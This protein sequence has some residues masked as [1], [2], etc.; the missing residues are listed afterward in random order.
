VLA[1]P[2][3]GWWLAQSSLPKSDGVA[4]VPILLK[5]AS[6][7]TDGRGVPNITATSEADLFRAQGYWT[8][9]ARLFQMDIYRRMARGE[10]SAIYGNQCLATDKLMRQIGLARLASEEF[11]VLSPEAKNSLKDYAAGVNE[12][13]REGEDHKSPEFLMLGYYP[14]T[15]T[16]ED[17]LAVLKYIQYLSEESWT[18]DDLKQRVLE[19]TGPVV[20]SQLFEHGFPQDPDKTPPA[21]P[22][23]K[24]PPDGV[25]YGKEL[26]NPA[27]IAACPDM[28]RLR[29]A[30]PSSLPESVRRVVETVP[31]FGSNAWLVSGMV[32][33]SKG[34]L[35]ALDRHS[36]FTDPNLWYVCTLSAGGYKAGG[37][38]IP[39]VP[40]IMYGRN[41]D[42]GWGATAYKADTQ[43]LFV[44]QFSAQFPNKYKTVQGWGTAKAFN[45][46]IECKSALQ[47]QIFQHKI[48]QTDHGP[49]LLTTEDRAVVLSWTGFDKVTPQ[50]E[51]LFKL[52]R[53]RDWNAFKEIL[54][55]YK[56]FS[57]NIYLC[58]QQRKYRLPV[59]RQYSYSR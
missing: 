4:H 20:A 45:E 32:S 31:G 30:L 17:T 49:V 2:V 19:K 50:Y 35:L 51:S 43:D 23:K 6:V 16:P 29:D 37:I 1:L 57:T 5:E 46:E 53:A 11:K 12:Y 8:A 18:L 38:T 40:G 36:S 27:K 52:N 59:G 13:I 41:S 25:S 22:E 39:G 47:K 9:T 34:A 54:K 14:R 48:T 3:L 24:P 26:L 55:N 44:E 58:G 33:D 21:P 42:I 28:S 7:V 56:R 15:W 10:L